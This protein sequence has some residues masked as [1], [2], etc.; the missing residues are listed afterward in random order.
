M[1]SAAVIGLA[2]G[3]AWSAMPPATAEPVPPSAP[4]RAEVEHSAYYPSCRAALGAGATRR[5]SKANQA[6]AKSSTATA[7]ALRASPSSLTD[8]RPT[9]SPVFILRA[10]SLLTANSHLARGRRNRPVHTAA[11]EIF[12]LSR[13][14]RGRTRPSFSTSSFSPP[15]TKRSPRLTRVSL[16]KPLRRFEV[17]SKAGR[18]VRVDVF[19]CRH[20]CLTGTRALIAD[21]CWGKP[22]PSA[23][24]N[25]FLHIPIW[26]IAPNSHHGGQVH[27]QA[28]AEGNDGRG[29]RRLV[30][31]PGRNSRRW[32][33]CR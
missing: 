9:P 3:Y 19:H 8:R 15:R 27:G 33:S 17:R 13:T 20:L 24:Q 32:R 16:G 30:A 10:T 11:F 2:G 31:T 18:S 12:G 4:T 29:V 22:S 5:F 23:A 21:G 26:F 25:S 14:D 6:I 7:T 1:L 28:S